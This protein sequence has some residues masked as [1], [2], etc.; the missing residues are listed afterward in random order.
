LNR[1]LCCG[2]GIELLSELIREAEELLASSEMITGKD[3]NNRVNTARIYLEKAFGE[4]SGNA[5]YFLL[6][7]S[8]AAGDG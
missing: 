4:N 6:S 8:Q 3:F 7:A 5:Q 1:L 2:A